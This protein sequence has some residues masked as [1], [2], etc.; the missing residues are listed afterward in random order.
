MDAKQRDGWSVAQVVT[1][2]LLPFAIYVAFWRIDWGS[3]DSLLRYVLPVVFC[4]VVPSIVGSTV[5]AVVKK[6]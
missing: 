2:V 4:V 3:G 5:Q 6:R 1:L